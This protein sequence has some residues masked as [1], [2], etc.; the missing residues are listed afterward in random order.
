MY[1]LSLNNSHLNT[2]KKMNY[3]PV[4]LGTDKFDMEWTRDNSGTNI[5]HKNKFYGENTFHYWIWKNHLK[6]C[7]KEKWLGFCHYRRFWVKDPKISNFKDLKS[8]IIQE[9][10]NEWNNYDVI[11]GN[12]Y[13][14]NQTKI[15]KII[16]HGRKQL[17][18]NPFVFF[19]GKK[20]QLKC[21]LTCTMVLEI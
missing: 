4:G 14:V 16:K 8:N 7:F 6:E 12:E 15:S 19:Q 20:R 2:I 18:K 11:L 10:P 5:S 3:I 1:C 21:I 17:I 9:I 13:F